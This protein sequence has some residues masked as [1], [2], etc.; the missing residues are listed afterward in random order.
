[1]GAYWGA[2]SIPLAMR[3]KVLCCNTSQGRKRPDFLSTRHLP[4]IAAKLVS[5]NEAEITLVELL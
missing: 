3:E 1:M 4:D 5:R 2:E